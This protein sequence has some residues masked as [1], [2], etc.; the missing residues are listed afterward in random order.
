MSPAGRFTV[1]SGHPCLPGH[2]P[3]R[4]VVPG[5]VLLDEAIAAVLATRPGRRVCG[6]PSAKFIIPVL[7]GQEVEI[8]CDGGDGARVAFACRVGGVEVA[9]GVVTLEA[10]P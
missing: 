4:P 10:G 1:A 7:P 9:R 6:L 3:D 8:H 2:F 5:V